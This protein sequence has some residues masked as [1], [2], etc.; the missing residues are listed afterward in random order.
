MTITQLDGKL[1][2]DIA[3]RFEVNI[4]QNNGEVDIIL[5]H[6]SHILR[7]YTR[8]NIKMIGGWYI[9]D[10]ELNTNF[11]VALIKK[12]KIKKINFIGA[13][14]SCSGAVVLAKKIIRAKVK[15]PKMN[16]FLFSAYTT[17]DKNIYIKRSII[18][19]AP[20]SLV[21]LWKSSKYTE[22]LIKELELRRLAHSPHV[23][24][25]LF[26]PERSKYG[27]R[28]LANRIVGS[29]VHHI[30]LP[31]YMH[32]TLYPMWK[33]VDENRTIEI[34]ENI[35]KKMHKDDHKFYL[36]MQENKEYKFHLYS[37]LE[38]PKLFESKLE[39]FII[40]YKIDNKLYY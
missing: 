35:V 19:K 39:N 12:Y 13:S 5:G 27:E 3:E 25:Y 28:Q 8:N 7:G 17:I 1:I 33:K 32:N 11:L 24:I 37:L 31:V 14:K 40:E 20:D 34:Y 18:D 4:Y 38:N 16:L 9:D 36:S 10:I 26:Y 6:N 15:T 22:D 2:L 30:A 29:N 23:E 21:K